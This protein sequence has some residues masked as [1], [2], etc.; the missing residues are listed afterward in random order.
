M[1]DEYPDEDEILRYPDDPHCSMFT[2]LNRIAFTVLHASLFLE[3]V[4]F[5]IKRC[6]HKKSVTARHIG[7][8][9]AIIN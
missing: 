8:Y 9:I 6:I 1:F 5:V 3:R 4:G 2:F 7:S